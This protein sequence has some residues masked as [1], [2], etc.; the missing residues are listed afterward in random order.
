MRNLL[1]ALNAAVFLDDLR[2]PPGNRLEQLS[3]D[4]TGQYSKYASMIS[5]GYASSGQIEG[6]HK[7]KL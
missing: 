6:R 5:G 4:R 1:A 2:F 7:S 3:G